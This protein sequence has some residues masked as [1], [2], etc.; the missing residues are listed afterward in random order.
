MYIGSDMKTNGLQ[1]LTWSKYKQANWDIIMEEEQSEYVNRF[2]NI[3]K[4]GTIA[5]MNLMLRNKGASTQAERIL[6]QSL[7]YDLTEVAFF[8]AKRLMKYYPYRGRKIDTI[9]LQKIVQ[10][11]QSLLNIE[12]KLEYWLM[13]IDKDII[14]RLSNDSILEKLD[15]YIE[16]IDSFLYQF[17]SLSFL[18]ASYTLKIRKAQLENNYNQIIAL[19]N[20]ATVRL[21]DKVYALPYVVFS[22]F[23]FPLISIYIEQKNMEE[24]E[25]IIKKLYT[26]LKPK[27]VNWFAV[28]SL[29]IILNFRKLNF[30]RVEELLGMVKRY[31]NDI[32]RER[33]KIYGAYVSLFTTRR[34]TLGKFTGELVK[35]D[36]DKKGHRVNIIIVHL[37]HLLQYKKYGIYIDKVEAIQKYMQRYLKST[38]PKILR[39]RYF[40]KCLLLAAHNRVNFNRNAWLR[41][42]EKLLDKIKTTPKSETNQLLEQEPIDYEYLYDYVKE[43]LK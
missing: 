24:A 2:T 33:N 36:K 16:E 13:D 42:T 22:L 29:E 15:N 32:N 18:L 25:Q 19:S 34:F 8:L 41:R 3:W 9:R 7:K 4:L 14:N 10:S 27:S 20:E 17:D 12:T 40:I 39:G 23:H 38:S 1:S 28:H 6:K 11:T 30:E 26:Q 21:E 37:L 5:N 35:H 43:R 31:D